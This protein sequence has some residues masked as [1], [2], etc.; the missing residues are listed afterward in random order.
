MDTVFIVVR[1]PESSEGLADLQIEA[2]YV[3]QELAE[4]R[5]EADPSLKFYEEAVQHRLPVE[6]ERKKIGR[7]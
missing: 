5:C 4:A 3:D 1:T 2:V 7:K 6:L